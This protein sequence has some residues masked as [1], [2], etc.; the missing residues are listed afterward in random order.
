MNKYRVY[1]EKTGRNLGTY[2]TK[3]GAQKRLAQVEYFK[4]RAMLRKARYGR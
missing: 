4:H 2:P 1:S 3:A